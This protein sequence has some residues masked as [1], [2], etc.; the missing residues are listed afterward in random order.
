MSEHRN[1]EH[2]AGEGREMPRRSNWK[3]AT[4][5]D[6]ANIDDPKRLRKVALSTLG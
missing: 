6:V 3:H 1:A 5:A 2:A 4:A